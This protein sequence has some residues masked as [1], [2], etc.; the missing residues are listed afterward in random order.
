MLTYRSLT[1]LPLLALLFVGAGCTGTVEREL[2][3]KL[4]AYIGPAE[5]YD[6]QIDGLRARSGRASRVFAVGERVQ[7]EDA[8]V[9]ERFEFDLRG[10]TYDRSAKRLERVDSTRA[11]ARITALAL[12]DFL[13]SKDGVREATLSLR[14]PD[15]A[16]LRVRPELGGLPVPRGIRAEVTGRLEASGSRV[17]F[18]VSDVEAAGFNL[19]TAAARRLSEVINP[20]VDLADL[21]DNLEVT[22][23]RVEG[24]AVVLEASGD[25]SGLQLKR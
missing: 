20:L 2:E 11:S 19:G 7:L 9:V 3:D 24:D 12:V 1:V 13:E 6:V 25:L 8:P 5:R 15:E 16:T 18:V 23:V 17:R 10:V 14:A 21:N 4:R 22:S